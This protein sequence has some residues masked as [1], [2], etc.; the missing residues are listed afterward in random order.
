LFTL[1]LTMVDIRKYDRYAG[2]EFVAVIQA[3]LQR[4]VR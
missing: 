3:E 2:K 4:R 1:D